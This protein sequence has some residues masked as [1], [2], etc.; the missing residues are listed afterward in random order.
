METN[1]KIKVVKESWVNMDS[2]TTEYGESFKGK[3]EYSKYLDKKEISGSSFRFRT[4]EEVEQFV[5]NLQEAMKDMK[6]GNK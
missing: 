6:G 4:V 5:A 3:V 1:K 2:E